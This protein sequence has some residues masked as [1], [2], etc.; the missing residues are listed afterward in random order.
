MRQTKPPGGFPLSQFVIKVD[1]CVTDT[2]F[3]LH[4]V[5]GRE[6][7]VIICPTVLAQIDPG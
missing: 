3:F 1:V 2:V 4:G 7:N 6:V 5:R